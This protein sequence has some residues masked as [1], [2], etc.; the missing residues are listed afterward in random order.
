[1]NKQL[2]ILLGAIALFSTAIFV[3]KMRVPK[4]TFGLSQDVIDS[5]KAYKAKYGI[6]FS[7]PDYEAYRI[8]VYAQNLK[9]I[10]SHQGGS[11]T[12]GV[13]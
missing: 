3:F 8:N 12:L 1:M 11:Y 4:P 6:N 13:N 7:D 2:L 10:E 9:K 5:Y